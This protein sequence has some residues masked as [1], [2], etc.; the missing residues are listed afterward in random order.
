[1]LGT[2]SNTVILFYLYF[3]YTFSFTVRSWVLDLT[4]F[5]IRR[6]LCNHLRLYFPV[7]SLHIIDT[8][9]PIPST[10]WIYAEKPLNVLK[11]NCLECLYW[12]INE[13]RNP[14]KAEEIFQMM[15][16]DCC[17][18]YTMLINLYGKVSSLHTSSTYTIFFFFIKWIQFQ[19]SVH[20]I[21]Y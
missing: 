20:K 17:D 10:M 4:F 3:I 15:K 7:V 19:I 14:Q 5:W 11:C 9:T 13:R 21:S 12:W 2:I 16:R 6:T 8:L 18:T 1:M